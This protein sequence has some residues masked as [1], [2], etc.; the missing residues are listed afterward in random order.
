MAQ[1][2]ISRSIFQDFYHDLLLKSGL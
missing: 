2:F 1:H